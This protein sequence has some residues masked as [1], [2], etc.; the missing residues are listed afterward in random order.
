MKTLSEIQ[1]REDWRDAVIMAVAT[2]AMASI[3]VLLFASAP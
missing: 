1:K 3:A 2:I